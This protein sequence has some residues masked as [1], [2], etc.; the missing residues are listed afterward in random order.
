MRW[1]DRPAVFF[2]VVILLL[3]INCPRVFGEDTR[4]LDKEWLSIEA[5]ITGRTEF[6]PIGSDPFVEYFMADLFFYPEK[7]ERLEI[8]SLNS[9]PRQKR[10]DG[11]LRFTW[12]NPEQESATFVV[13]SKLKSKAVY[14]FMPNKVSFPLSFVP[15]EAAAF[16]QET[17]GVDF[18]DPL[19]MAKAKELTKD[20]DDLFIIVSDIAH[21]VRET[22]NYNLST[23]TAKAN[24]P[25]SWVLEHKQGVCDELTNLFIAILRARGI[26]AKFVSGL[27]YT[28]AKDIPQA[29]GPHGWA[30]VYFPG[31]GWVPFDPTYGQH[32]WLDATHIKLKEGADANE[33]S[34]TYEWRARDIKMG[35]HPLTFDAKVTQSGPDLNFPLSINISM[36]RKGVAIGS[37]NV[38]TA[39][40]SN[41]ENTYISNDLTLGSTEGVFIESAAR[42]SIS[43]KPFEKTTATWIVRVN[44]SLPTSF[45]Y[46]FPMSIFTVPNRNLSTFFNASRNEAALSR[47]D[48]IAISKGESVK[49]DTGP[50]PS[51]TLSKS[52]PHQDEAFNISCRVKGGQSGL[53]CVEGNCTRLTKDGEAVFTIVKRTPGKQES[54]ATLNTANRTAYTTI[55]YIVVDTPRLEIFNISAPAEAGYDERFNLSV[56][57]RRM[58]LAVPATANLVII[59]PGVRSSWPVQ[60]AQEN[61]F[62]ISMTGADTGDS[63]KIQ[64]VLE[65]E[66]D[67]G[68][69]YEERKETPFVI[70]DITIT[71]ALRLLFRKL[72]LYTQEK[73]GK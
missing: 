29:W 30:E 33:P 12:L 34:V 51:C 64:A 71:Q 54:L 31:Y 27:S 40:I 32:G 57:V 37:Y 16:L 18:T 41:T 55:S 19:V 67:L 62:S 28:D 3:T 8:L 52:E 5:D 49:G 9:T 46:G 43:L 65:Y 58:S 44:E 47:E 53:L 61:T 6:M 70:T 17:E 38:I 56:T 24:K 11:K 35:I 63:G 68:N 10:V 50:R 20:K 45:V 4:Y 25:A 66:D 72:A 15:P 42:K 59:M 13:T 26:P 36:A 7:D 23:V 60:E 22:I 73:L 2:A 69:K 39:I 48:A 1:Y 21:Y 14:D